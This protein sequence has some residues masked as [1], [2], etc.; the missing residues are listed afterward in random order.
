M[1]TV[2]PQF[3]GAPAGASAPRRFRRRW[4]VALVLLL[5]GAAAL[6]ARFVERVRAFEARHATGPAWAF[7]SRVWSADIPLVRGALAPVPWLRAE[8]AARGYREAY[9]VRAPGQWAPTAEGAEIWLRGF[10]AVPGRAAAPERVRLRIEQGRIAAVRRLQ[11][12]GEPAAPRTGRSLRAR[13]TARSSRAD[14]A[15]AA[16]PPPAIE[17]LLI[18]TLADS[19][20]VAREF[21]PLARIPR[22]LQQAAIAAEDRRFRSHWGLDL[23]GNAR[24]LVANVRAGGVR[25]GA[26]TIT[27]Q[28]ARGLFSA[29]S[30][31]WRAS[32]PR[33]RSR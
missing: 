31:R 13:G 17:P 23:K 16:P 4:R 12:A 21:V 22:V 24:A 18:A 20:N 8:L 7:P 14:R 15:D 11:D 3:R 6:L 28:L 10:A 33:C 29:S 2:P 30:A 9:V 26:S 5:V 19:N 27:Q 32:S 25:Q 1:A